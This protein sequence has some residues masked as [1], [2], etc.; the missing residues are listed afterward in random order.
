MDENESVAPVK[1]PRPALV[2]E[3]PFVRQDEVPARELPF[4]NDL[5]PGTWRGIG[6]PKDAQ[7]ACPTCGV[8]FVVPGT[9][10]KE[11]VTCFNCGWWEKVR[12]VGW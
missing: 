11:A 10:L 7:I 3:V 1:T 4:N 8:I 9:D 5:R 2:A 12:L 6:H